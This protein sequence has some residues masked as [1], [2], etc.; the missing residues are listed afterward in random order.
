MIFDSHGK[1]LLLA[2][3]SE[4]PTLYARTFLFALAIA[5]IVSTYDHAC[6]Q[7]LGAQQRALKLITDTA[8][9]ICNVVSTKGEANSEEVK[10]NVNASL[11]GLASKLADAGISG[12]GSITSEQYQNVLRSDLAATLKDNA[13]C[14]LKVFDTLQ[15][16]LLG[17]EPHTDIDI[18]P[19]FFAGRWKM[20]KNDAGISSYGSVVDYRADGTFTGHETRNIL[21]LDGKQELRGRWDIIKLSLD[22]FQL[23]LEFSKPL[24]V[25]WV[26]IFKVIDQDH[27]QNLDENWIATRTR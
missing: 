16:K 24:S 10:G 13:A 20:Q 7:A 3:L 27:I 12:S 2:L 19:D 18:G 22:T 17:T 25:Q 1:P 21:G 4:R 11:R 14:K 5:A 8:D 9:K 23:N 15:N 6:A 26:R